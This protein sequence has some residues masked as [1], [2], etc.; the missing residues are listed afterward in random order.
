QTDNAESTARGREYVGHLVR[1]ARELPEIMGHA[2]RLYVVTRN[3]QQV[4][5]HDDVNLEQGGLRGLLRVSGAEHPH[6]K[7][8]H[9]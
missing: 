5:S 8:T 9:I 6:L 3:A 2:P 4:L 7:V 1:I